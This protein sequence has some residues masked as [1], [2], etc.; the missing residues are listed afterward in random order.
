MSSLDPNTSSQSASSSIATSSS[1][2]IHANSVSASTKDGQ[3]FT[4]FPKP[5]LALYRNIWKQEC[6]VPRYQYLD[7]R[8]TGG[9]EPL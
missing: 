8:F 4:L 9:K 3:R 6:F 1:G 2:I 7:P 5:L